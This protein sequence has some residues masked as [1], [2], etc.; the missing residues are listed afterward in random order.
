[1]VLAFSRFRVA[2][3]R[4]DAVRE[5]FLNRPGLVDNVLGFLGLEA[6]TDT[7]D[8]SL[9]YLLTRWT[10]AESFRRW[11]GGPDHK[12]AHKGIPKGL[13]LDPS[14]TLLRTL[15]RISG[16]GESGHSDGV[17]DCAPAIA[18]FLARSTSVLWLKVRS[19][20]VI[21]ASNRAFAKT[22]GGAMDTLEGASIWPLLT[23]PDGAS[24][25]CAVESGSR[26]AG[27]R[28]RL[29]FVGREQMPFTLECHVDVQPD[30][31][32][33]IGEAVQPDELALQSELMTLNNR[34]AVALRENGRQ[35]KALRKANA[36]LENALKDLQESHWHLRKIQEVLPICMGCGKVKTG[37]ATW[38]EVVEYFKRNC[39]FLSHAYCP[40]CLDKELAQ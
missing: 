5:A 26:D 30:G 14:F 38:E 27:K 6:F 3:G 37:D 9:F 19:D 1:M 39:L 7:E 28:C 16:A 4:G 20:G 32:V 2:N 18:E 10:D 15:D 29:N 23:E 11:H 35:A 24:L 34:L 40:A 36:G 12:Q 17:R 21:L 33:L 8:A 13:K 22:M 31:F 25:R